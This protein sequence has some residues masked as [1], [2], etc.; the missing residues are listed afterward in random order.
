M[1]GPRSHR[2]GWQSWDSNF[3]LSLSHKPTC[4]PEQRGLAASPAPGSTR[5][6]RGDTQGIPVSE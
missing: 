3:R 5:P 4:P 1:A 6:D 2:R